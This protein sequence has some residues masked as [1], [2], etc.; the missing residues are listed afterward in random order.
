MRHE[1]KTGRSGSISRRDLLKAMSI[2]PA[3]GLV[4]LAP[5]MAALASPGETGDTSAPYA[6]K[7]FNPHEWRTIHVLSDLIV[8]ADER[9]GSATQAGVPA[10]IDDWLNLKGGLLK[11]EVLGGLTWIDMECDRLFGRDFVD[12][13]EGQQK[14]ILD[15]IAYPEK[16]AP[17]DSNAVAAFNH[18]RDLVLEG[19]YS[20]KMGVEDLQYQGNKML[21]EW[22]GCPEI[23]TSRL[24]V[25]YSDWENRR[26]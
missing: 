3:A 6:P 11:T 4:P 9:T 12:C 16:A 18:I 14:Q 8:P 5:A 25:D 20:S 24:G 21:S 7:V 10:F 22:D 13:S 23:V 19:F 26:S 15:R 2:A 17:E 1:K